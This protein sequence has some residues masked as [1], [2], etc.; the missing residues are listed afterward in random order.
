VTKNRPRCLVTEKPILYVK[1][2]KKPA[3]VSWTE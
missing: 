2:G 3:S 1:S